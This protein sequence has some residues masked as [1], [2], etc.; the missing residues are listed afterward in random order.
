MKSRWLPIV[1]ALAA[2][3]LTAPAGAH[4]SF[5]AIYRADQ[6]IEIK[7][8]VV[9]LLF[10]NPH[11]ILHVLAPDD[12]G[13]MTRWA[14]EWQGATQLGAGGINAQSLR[15]GDPVIV[16]GNPGRDPAEHRIRMLSIKRTTDGFGW[17]TAPGEV[18]N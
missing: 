1:L 12:S 7:G 11:S 8:E 16:I 15:P 10:R 5:S 14:V 6:K 17:G 2:T 18:V 9:Q 3:A 4:H 13:A